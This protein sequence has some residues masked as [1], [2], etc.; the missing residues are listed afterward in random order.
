[1]PTARNRSIASKVL[2]NLF[3]FS[4]QISSGK[5]SRPLSDYILETFFFHL[6]KCFSDIKSLTSTISA[7]LSEGQTRETRNKAELDKLQSANTLAWRDASCFNDGENQKHLTLLQSRT[8][9]WCK[10]MMAQVSL[11]SYL[12]IEKLPLQV[13]TTQPTN[14]PVTNE[15]QRSKLVQS[16]VTRNTKTIWHNWTQEGRA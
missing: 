10:E 1:M 12:C 6:E 5:E 2:S 4:S 3:F 8:N 9:E 15:S 14:Q 13:C 7:V 16:H 11:L